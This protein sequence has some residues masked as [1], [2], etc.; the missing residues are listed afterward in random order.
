MKI[1]IIASSGGS[2]F[3]EIS[4][5]LR[6]AKNRYRFFVVTDRPCGIEEICLKLEI[7]FKRIKEADN[8]AFSKKAKVF[9]EECGGVDLL[10]LFFLRLVSK[11]LYGSLPTFNLH[12][13]LLP[14]FPGFG[15]IKKAKNQGV[16]FLGASLHLVSNRMDNGKI[17]AQAVMPICP[18]WTEKRLLK[19]SFVQKVYLSL[20]L[21]DLIENNDLMVNKA[22]ITVRVNKNLAISNRFNPAIRNRHFLRELK[23]LEKREGLS[24]IFS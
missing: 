10:L 23:A 16:K 14:A 11:D 20:L 2:V 6:I 17:I 7:T 21:F 12:P 15:A 8:K 9:F 22:L 5:I 3:A 13:S 18:D 24:V 19:I 1:G 4:R